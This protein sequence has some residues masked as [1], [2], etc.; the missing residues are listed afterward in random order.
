MQIKL[1]TGTTN[2]LIL[3]SYILYIIHNY[4]VPLPGKIGSQRKKTG[5]LQ[6]NLQYV[7]QIN[8]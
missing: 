1:L 7:L 5:N 2:E 4:V 3:G 8:W 6:N